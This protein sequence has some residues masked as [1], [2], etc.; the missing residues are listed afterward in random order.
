MALPATLNVS[1]NFSNGPTFGNPFTLDDPIYGKLGGSGVLADN[2]VYVLD[3]S[4]STVKIDTRRG[5]NI[6]QDLYEAGT[7]VVRVLDPTGIFD[8]QNVSS[9]IFGLMQP[10]R[11]LRISAT[12]TSNSNTYWI[13]SGYTTDYRYTYPVGQ[14]IAYVDISAVDGFRLFNMSNV[15][16]IT[17]GTA[18]Q[19]TGTRMD[20]ILDMVSWPNNMRS[21]STGNST[22]QASSVDTSVRSVLQSCRNVEQSEYGAF[23]M[24]VLGNAVFKS[25]S[26]VLASAGTAPTVFNQDGTGINYSNVTFA[27]DDKQ[28][29]NNVS[30]QRTGGAIQTASDAA[31]ITTYFTHSLSYSNLI[32]ETDTDALNIAK[33]YVNSHKDTTLRIDALQL[34][35]MTANYDAGVTAALDLDYFDQVQITNLQPSGSTITKTLQVQGIAHSITPN[36]WRTTLTTQEPIID[37]FILGSSLYGILGTSAFAY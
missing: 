27:F 11:K 23:Y 14:E 20:K 15:T 12:Q 8:P 2:A 13:F 35:L 6:N 29:V 34:D 17:N 37:G 25:R 4:D 9:P 10:L 16:T 30:V 26:E 24:D 19:T 31:S 36:T 22:C 32:V 5:R 3:V 1:I 33:A 18:G 28:V 21:I 7:A